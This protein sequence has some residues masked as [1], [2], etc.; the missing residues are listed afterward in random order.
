M[1]RR[2]E[3]ADHHLAQGDL[4]HASEKGWGSTAQMV[5]AVAERRGW[6]HNGHR[7]PLEPVRRLVEETGD[8]GIRELVLTANALHAN[9][10]GGWLTREDAELGLDRAR[11]LL[12]RLRPPLP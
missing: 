4:L 5:K 7:Q 9:F 10:Y 1:G 2:Q 3:K 6:P 11:Q 12:E 8:H